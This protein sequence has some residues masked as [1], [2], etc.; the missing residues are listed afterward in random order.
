MCNCVYST[1]S[2]MKASCQF[3]VRSLFQSRGSSFQSRGWS[4]LVHQAF[5]LARWTSF[6]S[7]GL[8]SRVFVFIQV[9]DLRTPCPLSHSQ[10]ARGCS[11]CKLTFCKDC[12]KNRRM[13]GHIL[14]IMELK[15]FLDRFCILRGTC[16]CPEALVSSCKFYLYFFSSRN[17]SFQLVSSAGSP[18]NVQS[19]RD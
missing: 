3:E 18:V 7:M 9:F 1:Q 5:F 13:R 16:K 11:V 15:C 14:L 12:E 19:L 17:I 10:R 8:M 2:C 4:S 6:Q